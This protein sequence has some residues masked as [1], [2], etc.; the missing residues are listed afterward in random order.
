LEY[1]TP[2]RSDKRRKMLLSSLYR[3]GLLS[4]RQKRH[5]ADWPGR[6]KIGYGNSGHTRPFERWLDMK[7]CLDVNDTFSA[8]AYLGFAPFTP[9]KW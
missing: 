7:L 2:L 4:G 6:T 8:K 9:L 1:N 3:Y 5:L